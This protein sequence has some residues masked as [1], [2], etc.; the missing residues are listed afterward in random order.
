[1]PRKSF[2]KYPSGAAKRRKIAESNKIDLKYKGSLEKILV[3]TPPS[4]ASASSISFL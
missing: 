1:M 3:G 2:C 4:N